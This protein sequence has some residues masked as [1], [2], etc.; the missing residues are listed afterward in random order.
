[1]TANHVDE[2]VLN[3]PV[4]AAAHRWAKE[5]GYGVSQFFERR[6]KWWHLDVMAHGRELQVRVSEDGHAHV[7]G[8][9][10][11]VRSARGLTMLL[12]RIERERNRG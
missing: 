4:R 11:L 10:G 5:R 1:V 3:R 6:T 8:E 7:E 9:P 2:D 12:N